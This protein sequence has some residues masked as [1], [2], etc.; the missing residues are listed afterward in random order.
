MI[1]NPEPRRAY[2]T[3]AGGSSPAPSPVEAPAATNLCIG[4]DTRA[5]GYFCAE[6]A[7]ID[8]LVCGLEQIWARSK[9]SDGGGESFPRGSRSPRN[10]LT[11]DA[12]GSRVGSA[13]VT[14][15]LSDSITVPPSLAVTATAGVVGHPAPA[16][17]FSFPSEG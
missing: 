12:T 3:A 17:A 15:G 1:T 2:G 13:A 7:E 14:T 6:C 9:G 5:S 10:T 11:A 4:C 8:A 16:V